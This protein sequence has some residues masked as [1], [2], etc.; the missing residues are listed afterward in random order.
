MTPMIRQNLRNLGFLLVLL[1]F[2]ATAVAYGQEEIS[3]RLNPD[4]GELT[5]G[6]VAHLTLQVEHPAGYQVEIPP[7]DPAWGPFEVRGQTNPAT[8]QRENGR[9]FTTQVI[10]VTL[11]QPGVFSTPPLT[12]TLTDATGR[13]VAVTAESATLTVNSVLLPGDTTLRDLKPQATLPV[14]FLERVSATLASSWPWLVA[15]LV[16]LAASFYLWGRKP[17]TPAPV[18][19]TRPIY[20]V[21]LDELDRVEALD[22]PAQGSFKAHYTQVAD[23]LRRYLQGTFGLPAMDQT[24]AEIRHALRPLPVPPEQKA[25]LLNLLSEADLVKFARM[26][27]DVPIARQITAV[28]RQF[29]LT[30][31]PAAPSTNGEQPP[32][33]GTE[34]VVDGER[35]DETNR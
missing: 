3:A 35:T 30:T 5:V 11:W 29:V 21:A 7:L 1:W 2:S 25:A 27:P 18:V 24:T 17:A 8:A 31:R 15:G 4:R 32:A 9:A 13:R 10:D 12:I 20:Q 16:A 26:V 23:I 33:N 6:D 19:D 28:A 22:L 34:P 14:P